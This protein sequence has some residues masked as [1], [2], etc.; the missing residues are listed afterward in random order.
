MSKE[1]IKIQWED[2]LSFSL[3]SVN[4]K[5][6]EDLRIWKNQN[7]QFFFYQSDI[8]VEQQQNWFEGFKKRPYDFMFIVEQTADTEAVGCMG[9]R[10]LEDENTADV[11][12][13]MRGKQSD[14]NNFSISD[15]F[16]TMINYILTISDLPISCKVLTD[17]PARNWYQRNYF[18]DSESINNYT[19]MK[20]NRD[21]LPLKSL[22]LSKNSEIP[23]FRV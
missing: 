7:K 13:I 17:N 18:E 4:E 8:T 19:L 5:D 3:R 12:N 1:Y 23:Y 20:L 15:A 11:Y 21:L 22:L 9:F 14:S 6:L 10:L 16:Q 2:N